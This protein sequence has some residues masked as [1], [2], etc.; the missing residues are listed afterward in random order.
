MT[1]RLFERVACMGMWLTFELGRLAVKIFPR[2]F[3]F[4]LFEGMADV[5]FHLFRSFRERSINNFSS[6]LG[7]RL[8]A[9]E[10]TEVVRRSLR[11]FFRDFVEI[12]LALETSP[13]EARSE[14]PIRGREH[15]EAALARGKGVIALS[16]HLGNFFLVGTRLAAEGY[17]TY[18]L[19][20]TSRDERVAQLRAQYR[21]KIGQ[22]TI[23]ARPR[24][25]ASRELVQVLRRNEVAIVIADEYRSGNGIYVPFFGRTVIAR[26]G[27]ATLALRTGAAVI[28]SYLIRDPSGKLRL[29]IEPEIELLRTGK[30]KMDVI[31]NTLRITQWLEKTV[32]SYPDQWNWMTVHWQ[33]S[34]LTRLVGKK[35]A[36]KESV[37]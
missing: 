23:H 17:P 3:L 1:H 27:P 9:K 4:S 6:A 19:V 13:E 11:N 15:L 12:G 24:Q 25:Q 31:E 33:D 20:N 36:A 35:Q 29:I 2:R 32:R 10:I 28:P 16:A 7:E 21:L 30:I 18:V 26:R 8:E 5:G 22:D 14:I 37:A 34:T